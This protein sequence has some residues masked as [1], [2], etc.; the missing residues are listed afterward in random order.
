MLFRPE[1]RK[2]LPYRTVWIILLAYAVLLMLFVGAG[3]NVTLNGQQLGQSLYVFPA[4]WSKLAYVASYFTMLL[5]VLLIILITDEF[6][7][8]TFRQQVIDGASVGE[9]VQG[10][11]A[12]S[13]VLAGFGMLVVLGVGFYFG[14]TRAAATVDQAAA[15]LPAVLFYG[16][17]VLGL[18]ALAALVAV[19]VRRSG[20]AIL[21][22]LLYLWVAEPLLRLSLPDELDRYLPAKI[23]NSLTPMPGQE[24]LDTVAG[25]SLALLPTQALPLALAYMALFWALSYL[26][27]RSRD[28]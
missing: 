22:F 25:P 4:L 7:F 21:V 6:Q 13:G 19:L 3:G 24:L 9:L 26:L 28:L 8:R 12:A 17:Q 5:G 20:A 2:I 18:L 16:A 27:L 23:F 10:K 11:L 14:L 1:L 15:G